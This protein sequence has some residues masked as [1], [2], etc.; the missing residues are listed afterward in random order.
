MRNVVNHQTTE[1]CSEV[2]PL[3]VSGE[4]ANMQE[5]CREGEKR[6]YDASTFEAHD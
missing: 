1:L 6:E 5:W 4:Y 2:G 3:T